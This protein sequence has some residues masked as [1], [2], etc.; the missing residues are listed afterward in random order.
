MFTRQ[1][2][3]LAPAQRLKL[4]FQRAL[5]FLVDLVFLS[6]RRLALEM[7]QAFAQFFAQIGESIEIAERAGALSS[8]VRAAVN[9]SLVYLADEAFEEAAEAAESILP[10]ARERRIG[11]DHEPVLLACM[12]QALARQGMGAEAVAIARE[13]LAKARQYGTRL[14]EIP[15]CLS[16]ACALGAEDREA[17]ETEIQAALKDAHKLID[18]TGAQVFT[19]WLETEVAR[20]DAVKTA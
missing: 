3:E 13:A 16:L 9:L 4:R 18:E 14:W 11:L 12:A 19:I 1:C 7:G 17:N 15:A 6:H 10:L 2:I 8:Q 5:F 20:S